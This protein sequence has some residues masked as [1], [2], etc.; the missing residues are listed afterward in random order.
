MAIVEGLLLFFSYV[1]KSSDSFVFTEC[2]VRE[3][4]GNFFHEAF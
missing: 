4:A 1:P 3:K 2:Q